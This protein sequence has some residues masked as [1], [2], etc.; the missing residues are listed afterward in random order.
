MLNIT[1]TELKISKKYEEEVSEKYKE[2]TD[3][4]EMAVVV[5][6]SEQVMGYAREALEEW[7]KRKSEGYKL[8]VLD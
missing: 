4:I 2:G 6:I 7:K 3:G 1:L 8:F 5:M